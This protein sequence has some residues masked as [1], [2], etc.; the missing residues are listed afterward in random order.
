MLVA[1]TT[2]STVPFSI[3]S[4]TQAWTGGATKVG[5]SNLNAEIGM[6]LAAIPTTT[7]AVASE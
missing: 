6:R 7:R 1:I 3:L 2:R 5:H 4:A